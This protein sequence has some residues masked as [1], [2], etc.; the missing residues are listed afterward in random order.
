MLLTDRKWGKYTLETLFYINRGNA[1]NIGKKPKGNIALISAI[2]SNN[3]LSS[4]S[5]LSDSETVYKEVYTVNNNGNGVCLA[6]WHQYSFISSSD[7]SVLTPKIDRLKNKYVAHFIIV[8]IERQKSKFNYGYKMSNDRMKRQTILL[9]IDNN[10]NIDYT[11]MEEYV[12]YQED[13]KKQE[14]IMHVKNSLSKLEYKEVP[15]LSE[16]EWSDFKVL[17]LFHYKRGNQNNMNSLTEGNDMLISA[18][19]INNGLKGFYSFNNDKKSLYEGDCI[20]LNNDGDGGVGL[21]YYQ[22]Y[23]FLL[24]THVYALYSKKNI[25][26][27]SKL[28]ITFSISKQRI[29]FSHGRSINIDRLGKMKILLPIMSDGNPDYTYMEQYIKNIEYKKLTQYLTY[30]NNYK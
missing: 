19:N 21:A 28:F 12:K 11:F 13:K 1:K 18:K 9:P 6:Y 26:K 14:Y 25:S 7:V 30:I 27:Y 5:E 29:C 20:T 15:A 8:C 10:E 24:D 4:F 3:G 23:K 2:D 17:D 16:K 22:P